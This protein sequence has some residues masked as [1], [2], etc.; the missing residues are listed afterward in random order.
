MENEILWLY[1]FTR[2]N[3]LREMAIVVVVFGAFGL[4]A[5]WFARF[6]DGW[7]GPVKSLTAVWVCVVLVTVAIPTQKDAMLILAGTG[8]I[9]AA[10]TDTA[11]RLAGK[12]VQV[13]EKALDDY[14]KQT[15]KEKS[16]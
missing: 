16:Q 14:L 8:V 9:Q 7:K 5:A 15:T 11:Q 2:L 6:I 10:K 13:I 4:L 12:S 3:T 1:L